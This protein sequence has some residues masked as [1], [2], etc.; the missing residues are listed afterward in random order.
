M[1]IITAALQLVIAGTLKAQVDPHFS[2]YYAYPMWL[3]PA[4]TGVINGSARV[5]ANYKNQ[6][7]NLNNAY[8]TTAISA[9]MRTNQN[10]GLGL[11][12]LNQAAG[13]V[14]FNY[15]SAYA[16]FSY[17][18]IVSGDGNQ[19]LNF[20]I[21]AGVLNRSFNPS[22]L[23]LGSQYDPLMGYNPNM[24]SN[25]TFGTTSTTVFDSGAGI[26]YYNGD[27]TTVANFFGGV[28][29]GHLSRPRDPFAVQGDGSRIPLRYTVQAGL[30]I[31]VGEML[32]VTPHAIFVK[33]QN[34]QEKLVGAYTEVKL[35]DNNGL[36]AGAMYRFGDAAI[37]NVGYDIKGLIIGAS[38]DF[39]TS[40]LNRATNSMG[41]VELSISYVFRKRVNEPDP[42]CP[43]L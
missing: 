1:I 25:E 15:F 34:A 42:I 17:G 32:D 40:S 11:N 18:I 43:R 36:I 39:N 19:R 2:Q 30:R 29:V 6:Y 8:K 16:N 33:Q 21:Q 27:P 9:D 23:Q 3:N 12:V 35:P 24:P 7:A 22:K 5:T 14:G 20:G 28:S 13:D 31:A 26:F 10:V 37:A 38:Y 41:G 4:L